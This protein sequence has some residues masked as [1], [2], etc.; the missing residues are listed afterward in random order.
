MVIVVNYHFPPSVPYF[1]LVLD[2]WY[3]AWFNH[4]QLSSL[5]IFFHNLCLLVWWFRLLKVS[6]LIVSKFPCDA[7]SQISD[8][9]NLWFYIIFCIHDLD[10]KSNWT[11]ATESLACKQGD[12]DGKNKFRWF[13]GTTRVVRESFLLS[14]T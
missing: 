7:T 4:C 12:I 5:I 2:T 3:I 8:S 9:A 10:R 11:S 14:P 6:G 1:G 13:V